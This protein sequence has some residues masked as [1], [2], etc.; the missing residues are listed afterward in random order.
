MIEDILLFVFAIRPLID[1]AWEKTLLFGL[2]LAGL[3]A[4]FLIFLTGINIFT[5][6]RIK[7]NA[8]MIS[9]FFYISFITIITLLNCNAFSDFNYSLRLFS[10]FSFF[11]VVAPNVSI[12][13]MNRVFSCFVVLTLVPIVITFLQVGGLVSFEYYDNIHG[14]IV[15]RGSGGYRQPS[16]LTRFCTIGLLYALYLL[17][18]VNGKGINK[19]LL[20]AYIVL[21][22]IAI[23]FSY[24][25][26]GYF[27]ALLIVILWFFLKNKKHF[28][29]TAWYVL[30]AV[31]IASLGFALL[32]K[33]GLI[34]VDLP[35]LKNMFDI[36]N[37]V[38]RKEDGTIWFGL[39]GRG[40]ILDVLAMGFRTNPWFYT[41]FGNGIDENPI[42]HIAIPTADMELIRV[43][44]NGG[45]IGAV[46][47]L[48]HF[49]SIKASIQKAR[50][51]KEVNGFYRLATCMFWCFIVWGLCIEAT[52]SPNL[53]YHV[54]LVC[55]WF[56]FRDN[57]RINI[58]NRK[59]DR[60][61]QLQRT[62]G[63][64]AI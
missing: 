59:G 50:K 38:S 31:L 2:N 19:Y 27:L 34:S 28:L 55:G 54:Y 25:R 22:A 5:H 21:N 46:L 42:T 60:T 12:E 13:K 16:V 7:T 8:P 3:V 29:R 18:N 35:T 63:N 11:L 56:C 61:Q 58:M 40:K 41:V 10:E 33:S 1:L 51:I 39:R 49:L 9:G 26:T 53:M 47:W 17:E 48:W 15:S 20:Y 32:F 24:H 37:I 64:I 52:E 36:S 62:L 57:V 30:I 14:V 23:V 6:N 45:I 4:V 43:L 44:W